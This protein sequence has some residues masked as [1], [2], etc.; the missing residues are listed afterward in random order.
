MYEGSEKLWNKSPYTL[1]FGWIT[2]T[3][4]F[5]QAPKQLSVVTHEEIGHICTIDFMT[6]IDQPKLI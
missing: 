1:T 2:S 4:G 3:L 5:G 6:I